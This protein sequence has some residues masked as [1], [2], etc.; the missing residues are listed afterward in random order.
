MQVKFW[1]FTKKENSTKQPS[2]AAAA[3]FNCRLKD[4]CSVIDPV[5]TVSVGPL[6]WPDYNYAYISDFHR[7]YFVDD[8]VAVGALFEM[9]LRCDLL[10]TY[11]SDIGNAS[12]YVLRSASQY[13]GN[14]IDEYYP[15]TAQ[16]TKQYAE[17]ISPWINLNQENIDLSSG[18]FV[19]GIISDDPGATNAKYGSITYRAF[20]RANLVSLVDYLL[21]NNAIADGV[22]GFQ[23]SDCS[24]ALQKAIVDPLSFIKSAIWIPISYSSISV[25]TEDSDT[26]IWTFTASGVKSKLVTKSNPYFMGTVNMNLTKHPQAAT[27]GIWLNLEPYTKISMLFPP[28][29]LLDLDTSLLAAETTV[30]GIWCV[31]YI[32]GLGTLTVRAGTI[33]TKYLKSQVGVPIQLSQVTHDIIS[34]AMGVVGGIGAAIVG[35]LTMNAAAIFGGAAAAIGSGVGAAKPHESTIGGSGS[36]SELH[37]KVKLYSEFRHVADENLAEVGRPLCQTKTISTLSGY[38]KA[39]GDVAIAGTAGEQ[40]AVKSLI[41]GGFFYE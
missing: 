33:A 5:I 12:L 32:T 34:G 11:K 6:T 1:K 30:Q 9:H 7:Y 10:A 14:L 18:C 36:F 13:D 31:D 4:P 40:S 26:P 22:N 39:L 21:G 28:F 37:G 41:E 24:I 23:A 8:I 35:A 3:T 15:I 38:V 17:T 20:D 19:L 29:G 16:I 27:R 2:G 25:A